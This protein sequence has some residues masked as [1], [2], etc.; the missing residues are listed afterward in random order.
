MQITA[1]TGFQVIIPVGA[2]KTNISCVS[3]VGVG[4]VSGNAV[5]LKTESTTE[6]GFR[7]TVSP[8]LLGG[9]SC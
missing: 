8:V 5:H 2:S 1:M 7:E 9:L 4:R 3:T 6:M